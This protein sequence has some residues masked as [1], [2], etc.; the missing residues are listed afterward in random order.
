[1]KKFIQNMEKFYC[2]FD[3]FEHTLVPA[4]FVRYNNRKIIKID[5]FWIKF[6]VGAVGAHESGVLPEV[7]VWLQYNWHTH[8]YY[9]HMPNW[10]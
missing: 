4:F 5:N 8:V 1:M 9:G 3:I 10:W 6:G 7:K 2:N